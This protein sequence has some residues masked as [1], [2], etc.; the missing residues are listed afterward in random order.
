MTY[1]QLIANIF[2]GLPPACTVQSNIQAL[3]CFELMK[4]QL[5]LYSIFHLFSQ[6]S[7]TNHQTRSQN[8]FAPVTF[9]VNTELGK[10]AFHCFALNKWDESQKTLKLECLIKKVDFKLLTWSLFSDVCDCFS[11]KRDLDLKKLK[12]SLI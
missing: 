9:P 1:Y 12:K 10:I 5:V 3:I 6:F 4:E 11:R 8:C 7:A 2:I